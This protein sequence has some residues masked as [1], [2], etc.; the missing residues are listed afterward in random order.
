MQVTKIIDGDITYEDIPKPTDEELQREY[1]FIL[2]EQMTKRMRDQGLI[3]AEEF[4]KIMERNR[5]SFS[6]YFSKL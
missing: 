4:D 1:D 3:S 2:A 6:P 5:K